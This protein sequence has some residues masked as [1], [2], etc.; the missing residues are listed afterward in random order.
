[1]CNVLIVGEVLMCNV[2]TPPRTVPFGTCP[3]NLNT[4]TNPGL[5]TNTASG[6]TPLATV[7][8]LRRECARDLIWTLMQSVALSGTCGLFKTA[9]D[10]QI[11]QVQLRDD[12]SRRHRIKRVPLPGLKP[13]LL[14]H[15]FRLSSSSFAPSIV[16]I[17]DNVDQTV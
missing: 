3:L 12:P 17:V 9:A 6:N 10:V 4:R 1:M 13:S 11:V 8:S 16:S 14:C 7:S 5:C 2:N 15:A